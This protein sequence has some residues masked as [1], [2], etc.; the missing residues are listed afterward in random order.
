M[1]EY[2]YPLGRLADAFATATTHSDP[3]T[4]ERAE[5][6]VRRWFAVLGGMTDGTLRIGSRTPVADLPAWVTPEVVRG[7]FATGRAAAGGPLLPHETDRLADFG[8]ALSPEGRAGLRALLD[9]GEY[10]VEVPEEAALLVMAWLVDHEDFDA[11]EELLREIAPFA[12]RLRFV[13]TPAAAPPSGLLWRE[14]VGEASAALAGRAPNPRVAAMNEALTVWNPFAD[15]LLELWLDSCED[16][17]LGARIDAAWRARAEA[18]VARYAELSATHTLTTKHRNPRHN[19]AIMLRCTAAVVRREA[20]G[21]RD[22]RLLE[23]TVEA[24]VARRGRP[25]SPEHTALR[26]RQSAQAALPTFHDLARLLVRRAAALPADEGAADVEAL[27]APVHEDVPG[28]PVGTP[29]P[30]TLA[31]IVRR[32]LAGT[33]EDL[34]AAGVVPSADV[35]ARLVPPIAAETIAR[36]YPEGPLRALMAAVHVAFGRRRSLLLLDFEH[37]VTVDELPWV[38][39]VARYRADVPA[40]GTV[41]RLGELALDGFPGAVLPN[42]L[43][44]E[45]A[46]LAPDLPWVEDLAADIFMGSFTPKFAAAARIAGDLLA[47]SPY[48][49]YYGLD[50]SAAADPDAFAAWCR[51]AATGGSVA[52]NGM[53]IEQAQI[54]TTHNL[55]TLVRAGVEADWSALAERAFGTAAG[56]ARRIQGNAR[57]VK[58]IAFAWRQTLFFLTLSGNAEAFVAAHREDAPPVLSRA[59]A[60]LE[61]VLHGGSPDEPLLGWTV[62]RHWALG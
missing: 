20:I 12:G 34:L 37:Q 49:R 29:I 21:P 39:A 30:G 28:I 24:M 19:L 40:H 58:N 45:L 15:D 59:L 33:A 8:H 60:G 10:R 11:A 61:H 3:A 17:R 55:A 44:R 1:D 36:A 2:G 22:R 43:V 57:T 5:A 6:R 27:L 47:D 16:T 51:R 32:A 9:S 56:L 18:L 50:Y 23:H 48:A 46:A 7:G 53:V 62:G 4:R 52:A 54:L 26:A 42:P 35:L 38:R 41:R 13:P 14:T 25:G 31:R